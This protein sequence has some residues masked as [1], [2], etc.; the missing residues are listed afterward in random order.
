VPGGLDEQPAGVLGAGLGDL[1]LAASL[2]GAAL[3][4]HEPDVAHQLPGPLEPAEVADLGRQAD[5]GQRV[6]PA[7]APQ[8][9]DRLRVRG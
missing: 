1:A 4:R 7:Q 6:D 9:G 3:R 8:P 5:R 2:A